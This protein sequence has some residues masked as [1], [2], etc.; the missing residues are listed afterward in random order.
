V[1][2]LVRRWTAAGQRHDAAGRAPR[3]GFRQHG[4]GTAPASHG[5][6]RRRRWRRP[7]RFPGAERADWAHGG[8]AC[9][10]SRA[11]WSSPLLP[12]DLPAHGI[13]IQDDWIEDLERTYKVK[14][15]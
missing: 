11:P 9:P 7:R 10:A 6:G 8:V 15:W 14:L 5:P 13:T 2:D 1:P 3:Q 4:N 12:R